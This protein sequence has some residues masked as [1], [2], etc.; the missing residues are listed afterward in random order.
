[1]LKIG[2][3][4]TLLWKIFFWNGF[5]EMIPSWNMDDSIS[6]YKKLFHISW[7]KANSQIAWIKAINISCFPLCAWT[8]NFLSVTIGNNMNQVKAWNNHRTYTQNLLVLFSW[9]H[10]YH[11]FCWWQRGR[12]IWIDA[13]N[14]DA[15]IM[16]C[17][18][19]Q[20][21]YE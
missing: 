21:I 4:R 15:I 9:Y 7:L 5:D 6:I 10:N 11:A 18:H 12:N 16:P 3:S 13:I 14:T 8:I 2:F 1:M 20:E 19:H 17:L